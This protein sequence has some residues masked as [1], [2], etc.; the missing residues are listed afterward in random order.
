MGEQKVD[1]VMGVLVSCGEGGAEL[2]GIV[3]DGACQSRLKR[4]FRGAMLYEVSGFL[5]VEM[6][7]VK[8]CCIRSSLPGPVIHF[9]SGGWYLY[10]EYIPMITQRLNKGSA[11]PMAHDLE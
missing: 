5:R 9:V 4:S 3:H 6:D 1:D 7:A 8:F 10:V 2:E 11:D